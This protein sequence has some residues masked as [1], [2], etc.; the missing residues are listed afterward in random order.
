[1]CVQSLEHLPTLSTWLFLW[2]SA[3]VN[4]VAV[5][6]TAHRGGGAHGGVSGCNW[7]WPNL[8]PHHRQC[9]LAGALLRDTVLLLRVRA[10]SGVKYDVVP[11]PLTPAL[12]SSPTGT[13]GRN[14]GTCVILW[15]GPLSVTRHVL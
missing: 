14:K 8:R 3:N 11:P 2:H 5:M 7:I 13:A 10:C 9:A 6:V 1:M 4:R 12:M 15:P